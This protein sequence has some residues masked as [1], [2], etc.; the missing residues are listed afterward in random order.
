M[1]LP[2]PVD[3]LLP[4]SADLPGTKDMPEGQIVYQGVP[5]P[6]G[7]SIDGDPDHGYRIQITYEG[8]CINCSILAALSEQGGGYVALCG[9]SGEGAQECLSGPGHSTTGNLIVGTWCF[10]C[11]HSWIVTVFDVGL[12]DT[13]RTLSSEEP[14]EANNPEG[15]AEDPVNSRS[16]NLSSQSADLFIPTRGLPLQF[17][18]AYN[19]LD[20]HAGPLGQGWTHS[21]DVRLTRDDDDTVTLVA[22][23]GSRLR[24]ADNHD[25]SFTP[26]PGVRATMTRTA[27]IPYTY[28]VT[29]GDQT[30]FRF[31]SDGQLRT[32]ADRHGDQTWLGYTNANGKSLLTTVVGPDGRGILLDYNSAGLVISATD[33]L[34][35]TT[36]YDY[37]TYTINNQT[38]ILDR[39]KT[40]TDPAG[41]VTT[42][43]YDTAGHLANITDDLGHTSIFTYSVPLSLLVEHSDVLGRTTHFYYNGA[44]T[45]IVDPNGHTSV[46]T[47]DTS[48]SS[49][50]PLAS[51]TDAASHT[52]SYAYDQNYNRTVI[53]DALGRVTTFTWN[54]AGCSMASV[55][56]PVGTTTMAYDAH[57]N[58]TSR[59]DRL[60]RTISFGYDQND[61]LAVITNALG[62]SNT[63]TYDNYGQ[64]LS[65]T[66]SA[67]NVT[68]YEYDLFGNL[69]AI[70]DTL[71]H[72]TRL[73]YDGI[74]NLTVI[75]DALGSATHYEYDALNRLT[76]VFDPLENVTEYGYDAIGRRTVITDANSGVTRFNYDAA[77]QLITV[78]NALDGHI[79]YA[80]D[81][82]GN[83]IAL[84]DPLT[85]TTRFDYDPVNR[86]LTIT[87]TLGG[88]T[89]FQ[90]D[91]VGNR[92]VITDANDHATHLD[93]DSANR[94]ITITNALDGRA[95]YEYDAM[96]NVVAIT[97]PLTH[98]ARL[99]Y[100]AM[101]RPLAVTN[102][103][104]AV[105]YYTYDRLGSLTVIT[106]A[107]GIATHYGYDNLRRLMV[108]T[109]ALDGLTR[110]N[111]D[112]LGNR[113]VITDANGHVTH[114]GYDA[115]GQLTSR[116]DPLSHTWSYAYDPVGVPVVVTDANGVAVNYAYDALGRLIGID[117]PDATGDVSYTY[118][119]ASNRLAMLDATG[120]TTYTYDALN[121]LISFT[122]PSNYQVGY[123]YDA[124]GNL[125][126]LNYPGR[127]Y[128]TRPAIAYTY[129]D[130]NRLTHAEGVNGSNLD[131]LYNYDAAGRLVEQRNPSNT[132]KT[133][134]S[135]DDAN[136]LL[137]VTHQVKGKTLAEFAYT[138]DAVGNRSSASDTIQGQTEAIDYSY[139]GLYRLTA[140]ESNDTTTYYYTYDAVGNRVEADTYPLWGSAHVFTYTYDAADRMTSVNNV[141]YTWD[142]NGSLLNDGAHTFGYNA[143]GRMVTVTQTGLSVNYA[144]NGDGLRVTRSSSLAV[145]H[146][147]WDAISS[148]PQLLLEGDTVYGY[149]NGLL[150]RQQLSTSAVQNYRLDGLGSVRL[151]LSG[152]SPAGNYWYDPFGQVV[153]GGADNRRRFTS[154]VQ[155][156]ATGLIYLRARDYDPAT[157]RFLTRDPFHGLA[158]LPSTQNPYAY[159]LNNPTT[160]NDPSGKF[161]NIIIGALIG[162]VAGYLAWELYTEAC[163]CE[164]DNWQG[165]LSVIGTGLLSGALIGSGV[166]ILPL[167]GSGAGLGGLGYLLGNIFTGARFS[168]SQY[169]VAVGVGGASGALAQYTTTWRLAMLAGGG[170]NAAQYLLSTETKDWDLGSTAFA[171]VF[172]AIAGLIGG[173]Y[174]E[175]EGEQVVRQ[176]TGGIH[177]PQFPGQEVRMWTGGGRLPL[178][179]AQITTA[180]IGGLPRSFLGTLVT[181]APVK[182]FAD[183]FG[184]LTRL[185]DPKQWIACK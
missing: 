77:G 67:G 149:G 57:N 158:G 160:Y 44:Q 116:A 84:T 95:R 76:A 105:T 123:D 47:Y 137:D 49:I 45:S 71:G 94:L 183:L 179:P 65:G 165:M 27:T 54:A 122:N 51:I 15:F 56:D 80:Y 7:S 153:A 180:T 34:S 5:P 81:S 85:H 83:L 109:D 166:G 156:D 132:Y 131:V 151:L 93:Y 28:T 41:G 30:V 173:P 22:P 24:F 42:Y 148:V 59:V 121:R 46:H 14:C 82:V 110:Y 31:D 10:F 103:L 20:S 38:Y 29:W 26:R 118:D 97:D 92:T 108:I 62:Y 170:E 147:V 133:T 23:R 168:T 184:V 33:P 21:Y 125:T 9:P 128:P 117:Y 17:E 106:D 60:N 169:F 172:G 50:A 130:L 96:N 126:Q 129:D 134:Y 174:G 146:Y 159:A 90:Y 135:Y 70:T 8:G 72:V 32:I 150:S 143:A 178:T 4:S 181:D 39:L 53:T 66:D 161:V 35:R 63:L 182:S 18:R 16:G 176:L 111:Y 101:D 167:I 185:Q 115:L 136:R 68:H 88:L 100:D 58:L 74:G 98:T 40:V 124:V 12:E 152:N 37:Y 87:D 43:S 3:P 177:L 145:T 1:L 107:N 99:S 2:L 69:T 36:S 139:D 142:N 89:R 114:L 19:S 86:L 102:T 13:G 138:Y 55:T 164:K 52:T 73:G 113:T 25:G 154:E 79:T 120:T 163:P 141:P 6:G 61:N 64:M 175:P 144:Y 104:N 11:P 75:T 119:A 157:G 78:T 155:D 171:F 48:A 127:A 140:A 112:A 162:A 91:A